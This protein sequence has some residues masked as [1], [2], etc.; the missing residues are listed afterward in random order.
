MKFKNKVDVAIIGGGIGGIMAAYRLIE[1]NPGRNPRWR[2]SLFEFQTARE[3][4]C[5][6]AVLKTPQRFGG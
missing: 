1:K 3:L 2:G 4:F 6:P 5:P